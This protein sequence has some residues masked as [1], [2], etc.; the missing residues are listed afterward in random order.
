MWARSVL[1]AALLLGAG[2]HSQAVNETNSPS[3]ITESKGVHVPGSIP[4][5]PYEPLQHRL[6][7]AGP[8][9]MTVSWST[10]AQI[11]SPE[12]YYGTSPFD[13]SSI[14]TG[15][16]VTYPTSRVYDNH[17]KITGLKANTKYWYR[18]QYQNCPGCAYR[19]TDTFVT[20]REAGDETPFSVAVVVDLGLMGRDG[21]S[22]SVGPLGGSSAAANP[23]GPRD[24]NTIQGLLQNKDTYDFIAHYGDIAYAD[25]FI[26]ESWQGYFGNNSLIPNV[27]SVVDGYNSLLEQYYDQM[28]PLTSSKAYMVGAGNHEANCDNGGT[29]DAV[30]NIT[31]TTSICTT[32]QTNFTGYI[33]HFRMPSDE[34]GGDG[35]FWYS[36]DYGL[37]HFI[38]LDSETDLPVG[39]Q[40]PD[41]AGGSDAGGD[42]GPF[43]YP[44][45]QI[46]W[47]EQ[48]LASVDRSKTP[49]IIIG[50]HRPWYIAAKND[51]GDVCLACQQ[52]FE[53]LFLKYNVDLYMQGHVHLYERNKPIANYS[54]DPAGLNNP[55]APWNIVNG[56]AG[57][58][59]GLDTLVGSP[60]W[61]DVAI[62]TAY[63]WSRLTFHN[64]THLTHEFVSSANGTILDSA[65]L[66]KAHDFDN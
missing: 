16:S 3:C 31:Y 53:P 37:A 36:F 26:K 42:N 27:T 55:K 34:S 17:V 7:Y 62:D 33:N 39:L 28:T 59:D 6:A 47:L 8:N 51:S 52:A 25:Y 29:T 60:Y 5:N 32:G 49:W 19:A 10:Y 44:N 61:T 12:V 40:S 1:A 35:N 9:G 43:G 57:H 11:A 41:E 30:H 22:T 64:R 23:L 20:A 46:Q 58:Y 56:A 24:L 66:Y 18:V 54:I 45:E 50:L 21:L 14:A 63:G 65:T 38:T 4:C 48:D 2:V 13:V 15:Y